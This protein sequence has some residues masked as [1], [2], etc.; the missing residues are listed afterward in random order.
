MAVVHNRIV[1]R[2][3]ECCFSPFRFGPICVTIETS[4]RGM[5]ITLEEITE[6]TLD[7]VLRLTVTEDQ[8]TFVAPVPVS[9]AQ[10][11][12]SRYA[13]F[14]AI[15]AA[16][17]PVGFV[18]LHLDASKP[19]YFLWRF[20]IDQRYQRK[21]YGS[22]AM[23]Q[24]IDFV[25]SLPEASELLVSYVPKPGNPGDFYRTFGFEETGEIR[26]G[27]TVMRLTLE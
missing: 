8:Y 16:D 10:A 9:I 7:D 12:F 20:L 22:Q 5:K 19:E 23:Q 1:M 3:P 18:M 15:Y 11:H 21:G 24:V 4:G 25:K 2:T 17:T 27:E 14:R 26:D 13:W 6:D